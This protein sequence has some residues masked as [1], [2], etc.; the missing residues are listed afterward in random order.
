MKYLRRGDSLFQDEM[1]HPL[2]L[3]RA[4]DHMLQSLAQQLAFSQVTSMRQ[5]RYV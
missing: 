5:L 2:K 3:L 4:H 1:S